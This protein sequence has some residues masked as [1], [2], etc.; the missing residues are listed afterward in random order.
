MRKIMIKRPFLFISLVIVLSTTGCI[1]ET[2]NMKMLSKQ[3]HLS[4]V[5]AISAV[6]GDISFG[7]VVKSSDTV[8]FDQNK[9]VTLIFKKDSIVDLKLADFTKATLVKTAII[10]PGTFD[11]N[12]DDIL[13]HIT[14]D[15]LI[16]NPILKFNYSNS[17]PDSVKI[18]LKASGSRKDKTINLNL[19]PFG[20]AKPNLPAQQVITSSYTIN[21]SNSNLQL[22]ISLPPEKLNYSGNV[23]LTSVVKSDPAAENI[24]GPN[25]VTGSL[26]LEVPLELKINNLQFTDTVDNFIKD[27]GNNSDNPANPEDFQYLRVI[28]S[29]KNGFPLGAS[30]KMSL[31]DSVTRTI[32]NSVEAS[33]ILA[34][35]PVDS[36]GKATGV[37]ESSAIIEFTKEFFS[38]VNKADKIIFRFTLNSTGN[39]SQ[40]VKIYSDYR[41]NFKAALVVKPDINLK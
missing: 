40:N 32:K 22:L 11:L 8:V 15:F 1:K 18:F 31:Y 34:P 30:V 20:L 5:L 7:D 36:N 37:T 13:S 41:I 24:L 25:R 16:A 10:D 35:A 38:T 19:V 2:Y 27:D 21:K 12:I 33:G 39:G 4:P 14:G 23:T 3:A 9:F 26:E 6:K 17:F 29:A 28:M